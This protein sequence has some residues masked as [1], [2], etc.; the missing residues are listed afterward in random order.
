MW[1]LLEGAEFVKLKVPQA[2]SEILN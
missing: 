2:M 1:R